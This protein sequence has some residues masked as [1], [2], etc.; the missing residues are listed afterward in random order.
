MNGSA[1]ISKLVYV[2]YNRNATI[3]DLMRIVALNGETV[4]L[5]DSWG[6]QW[7]VPNSAI[8]REDVRYYDYFTYHNLLE[9]DKNPNN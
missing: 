1:M 2:W 4:I 3:G 7:L 9:R 8:Q 6:R 5:R